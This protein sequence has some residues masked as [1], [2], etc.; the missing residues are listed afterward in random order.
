MN[1]KKLFTNNEKNNYVKSYLEKNL[2]RYVKIKYVYSIMNKYRMNS[3]D[4]ISNFPDKLVDEYLIG[5]KQNIDPV[6]LKAL[7]VVTSFYW[8]EKLKI[9]SKWEMR[10]IFSSVKPYNIMC[11]YTFV[12]H[13][14]KNNLVLLSLYIDNDAK[15]DTLDIIGKYKDDL[16]GLLLNTQEMLLNVY[17]ENNSDNKIAFT[18]RESEILYWYTTGKTHREIADFLY[19]SIGTVKS[20]TTNI[21]KKMGVRNM[22]HAVS[23]ATE[24]KIISPPSEKFI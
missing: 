21:I 24:L 11:G 1:S 15:K 20:Y 14:H 12:L 17:Y 10:S 19:L 9:N 22:R 18:P 5:G 6:I 8:D 13:D 2:L 7:N 4:I 16:Q 3:V 23:L